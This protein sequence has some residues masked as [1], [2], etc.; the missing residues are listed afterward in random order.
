[1]D[2]LVGKLE[3]GGVTGYWDT[4]V[5][6]IYDKAAGDQDRVTRLALQKLKVDDTL[7]KVAQTKG[8]ISDKE[9]ALFMS[10]S[11]AL[12]DQET[13]WIDWINE[14][15]EALKKVRQRLDSGTTVDKPASAGQVQSFTSMGGGT[16]ASGSANLTEADAIVAGM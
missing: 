3:Q 10:P 16:T 7:L 14:R 4:W 11:P 9:M 5:A 12:D 8:A 2:D 15:R 6:G 1:M 13:V